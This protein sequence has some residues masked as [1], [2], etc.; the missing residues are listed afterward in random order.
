MTTVGSAAG[1]LLFQVLRRWHLGKPQGGADGHFSSLQ[2]HVRSKV[3]FMVIPGDIL[4]PREATIR[5]QGAPRRSRCVN[6]QARI[7]P[8]FRIFAFLGRG[9]PFLV[10]LT[11]DRTQ[12]ILGWNLMRRGGLFQ[13]I[14]LACLFACGNA[15]IFV[16][17]CGP[18]L[19]GTP[20]LKVAASRHF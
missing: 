9:E 11:N 12:Y 3:L 4:A 1:S 17:R 18:Q 7:F 2:G 5:P 14:C 13:S 15:E 6:T 19:V 16:V 20:G 10:P 8:D